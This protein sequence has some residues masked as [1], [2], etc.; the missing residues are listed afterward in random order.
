METR[1]RTLLTAIGLTSRFFLPTRTID[2]A[3]SNSDRGQKF[4]PGW[5]TE[6]AGRKKWKGKWKK[7]SEDGPQECDCGESG[8]REQIRCLPKRHTFDRA[9]SREVVFEQILTLPALE[10]TPFRIRSTVMPGDRTLL[11]LDMASGRSLRREKKGGSV[12]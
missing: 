4:R 11:D 2:Q 8:S 1:G 12:M 10:E 6:R 3:I 5:T 7:N 9:F